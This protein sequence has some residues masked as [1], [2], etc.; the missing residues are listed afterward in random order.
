MLLSAVAGC[1]R[2]RAAS[3]SSAVL[4]PSPSVAHAPTARSPR[5]RQSFL[6]IMLNFLS[7]LAD[8][9]RAKPD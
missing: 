6:E 5:P 4:A 9:C 1:M 2:A 7:K 8:G 3:F